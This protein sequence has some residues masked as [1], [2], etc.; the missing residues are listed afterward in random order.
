MEN[1]N[2]CHSIKIL[3]PFFCFFFFRKEKYRALLSIV[4][5]TLCM[6]LI[7]SV[8]VWALPFFPQILLK[9]NYMQHIQ[10]NWYVRMSVCG[11]YSA[12]TS[13]QW[14]SLFTLSTYRKSKHFYRQAKTDYIKS[15]LAWYQDIN[16][17]WQ[18]GMKKV[19]EML[20]RNAFF[21]ITSHHAAAIYNNIL[22][23]PEK[24]FLFS[25]ILMDEHDGAWIH[26][27]V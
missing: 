24:K 12:S 11:Q 23:L 2:V 4:C 20:E 1:E 22:I 8:F 26:H 17:A 15:T 14:F 7:C 27:Q 21:S 18:N 3:S 6:R 10:W 16:I 5:V 13:N 25:P 19:C 9:S